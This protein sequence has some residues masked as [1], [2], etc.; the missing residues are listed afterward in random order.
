MRTARPQ[1]RNGKPRKK[2]TVLGDLGA[3]AGNAISRMFGLGAYTLKSNTIV[4][5]ATSKQVPFM[6]DTTDIV[7]IRH[8]EYV[9]DISSSTAFAVK[10]YQVNPGLSSLFPYLAGIASNFT[11]YKFD[12]L[13]FEYKS[14]SANALNSTN[15]ALGTVALGLKYDPSE[16]DFTGKQE[17]L[18]A[19]WSVDGKPSEDILLPVECDPTERPSLWKIVRADEQFDQGAQPL[20]PYDWGKLNVATVGSQAAAVVGELW[21]SYDICFTKPRLSDSAPCVSA[22]WTATDHDRNNPWGGGTKDLVFNNAPDV[23]SIYYNIITIKPCRVKNWRVLVTYFGTNASVGGWTTP[24]TS[25]TNGTVFVGTDYSW[26]SPETGANAFWCT[27]TGKIVVT[28][29]S[30]PVTITAG[31]LP[32]DDRMP[33][34]VPRKVVVSLEALN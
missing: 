9:C 1:R 10:S 19:M 28:D 23:V 14:M 11:E 17:L 16:L 18:N 13:V 21:V 12:G 6:H 33:G 22:V 7:R 4:E 27:Y 15:T 26:A 2:N 32:A 34:G 29:T 30:L 25:V 31:A 8:R 5:S 3:L 24:A 20:Q